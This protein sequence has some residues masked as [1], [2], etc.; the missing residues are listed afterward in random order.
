MKPRNYGALALLMA[1]TF[2]ERFAYYGFRTTV[3]P[4]LIGE[5]GMA[6]AR[7]STF[8]AIAPAASIVGLMIGGG[9]S[10]AVRNRYLLAGLAVLIALLHG[11][12][13]AFP[14]L[15]VVVLPLVAGVARP[16]TYVA[17]AEEIDQE[18]RIWKAVA[19]AVGL[20]GATNA[21]AFFAS[22][23]TASA[24]TVSPGLGNAIPVLGAVIAIAPTVVLAFAFPGSPFRWIAH[25]T[26]VS[27]EQAPYRPEPAVSRGISAPSPWILVLAI[28]AMLF[29]TCAQPA[30][31]NATI[32]ALDGHPRNAL[33]WVGFLNPIVVI[34]VGVL[35]A[36]LA[37]YLASVRARTS[38]TWPM[39]AALALQVVG[40]VMAMVAFRSFSSGAALGATVVDALAE[41]VAAP[42]ALGYMLGTLS[43]RWVGGLGAGYGV[44][45]SGTGMVVA[46][47][48]RLDATVPILI[49]LAL[50]LLVAAVL[51]LALGPRLHR[52]SATA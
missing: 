16:L 44:V 33:R 15:G 1:F 22:L 6:V 46:A 10:M 12:A 38:P 35:V 40:V 24:R 20:Y 9:L 13:A 52:G 39:G 41:G 5:E 27:A 21:G 30:V 47:V 11:A 48:H 8:M 51:T 7:V 2:F 17:A 50:S 14:L 3:F 18:G 42:I 29:S 25:E 19:A 34:L 26:L 37:A 31:D 32:S 36:G 4:R 23:I 28:G 43:S 45:T 49:L